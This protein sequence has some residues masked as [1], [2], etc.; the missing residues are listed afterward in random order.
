MAWYQYSEQA[1]R[2]MLIIWVDANENRSLAGADRLMRSL[3]R[4]LQDIAD[5]PGV[6]RR[7]EEYRLSLRS[8]PFSGFTI[9]YRI[10][11]FGILVERVLYSAS[12]IDA[13]FPS[14]ENEEGEP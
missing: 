12:D 9:F 3:E 11:D 8:L 1:D 14:L 10:T 5:M 2:D 13:A 6:G 7:R 4:K